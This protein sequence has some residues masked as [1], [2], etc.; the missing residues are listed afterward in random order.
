MSI[1]DPRLCLASELGSLSIK[2]LELKNAREEP[3]EAK[4]ILLKKDKWLAEISTEN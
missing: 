4:Q 2:E 1:A 3:E